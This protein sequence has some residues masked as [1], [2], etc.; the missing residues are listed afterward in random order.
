MFP[1]QR[2]SQAALSEQNSLALI[3]ERVITGKLSL[4]GPLLL[5]AIRSV[6]LIVA[7]AC[8]ALLL[9]ARHRA[10]PWRAAADWWTVYGTAADLGCLVLL[11]Y[12]T[13]REGIRFRDL[14]G[15]VR[16]RSGRDLWLG[17]GF[18]L[19][20]FPV[21][22]ASGWLARKWFFASPADLNR[23]LV[24]LHAAPL[25]AALYGLLIWWVLWSP[26]EEATYQGYCLPRFEA[27]TGRTWAGM[28]IVG[29][30]WAAQHCALPFIPDWRYL[31]YRFVAFF[32]GVIC[33]MLLYLR[34]RRLTPLII[35][36]WPMDIAAAIVHTLY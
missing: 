11:R 33:L 19:M 1:L 16:L 31:A 20:V 8:V 13:R 5:V 15:T 2:D 30:W 14:F 27:L 29:F 24:H 32:P 18:F 17:L 28:L 34:T 10:A 22:V 3:R 4:A 25:W 12:F 23:S 21:F 26:T 9:L 36:H 35:A 7:Q 6:L